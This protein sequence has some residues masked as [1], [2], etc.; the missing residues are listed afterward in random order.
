[1]RP[2]TLILPGAGITAALAVALV[3]C[4][5]GSPSAPAA[6]SHRTSGGMSANLAPANESAQPALRFDDDPRGT[7]RLEGQVIDADDH[8]VAGA[9]VVIDVNPPREVQTEA[10]GAFAFRDLTP[11]TYR[12]A[13]RAGEANAGPVSLQL[14]ATTD[15]DRKSVV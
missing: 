5:G 6:T 3:W 11:R 14:T 8:P 10:D 7:L 9:T 1:M 13:A 4:R 12:V 2:R 15:Q